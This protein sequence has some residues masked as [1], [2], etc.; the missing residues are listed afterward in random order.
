MKFNFPS[1]KYFDCTHYID[2][3]RILEVHEARVRIFLEGPFRSIF[4]ISVDSEVIVTMSQSIELDTKLLFVWQR[5]M[6]SDL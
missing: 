2:A 6:L 3:R 1:Q 5:Q 4:L